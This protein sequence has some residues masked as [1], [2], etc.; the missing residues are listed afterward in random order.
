MIE[1]PQLLISDDDRD[2]RVT[3]QS[4]F[5]RSGF[6]TI[7]AANGEEAVEIVKQ[8]T[9]HVVLIDMHMPKKTGLEAIREIK[10][11]SESIPCILISAALDDTIR[12]EAT[13][14]FSLL[15]KPV[16]FQK[17]RATVGSALAEIY[18]WDQS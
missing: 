14:A 15:E 11:L 16:N 1:T 9:V 4:V 3:L 6:G 2:F 5:D 8:E 18:G 12:E 10:E 13:D 17:V 7:L